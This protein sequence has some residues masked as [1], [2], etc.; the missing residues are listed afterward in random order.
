VR[1]ALAR[2]HIWLAATATTFCTLFAAIPGVAVLVSLYALLVPPAVVHQQLE[3]TGGLLPEQAS[4]FLA[5]Q[6]QAIAS[7]PQLH[8]GA[9]LGGA[10]LVALWSARAGAATLIAACNYAYRERER[11]SFLRYQVVA[12]VVT[13]A[14]CLFGAVVF[15]FVV[16]LPA[17]A[18]MLPLG[19][20]ARTAIA[21]GRWPA[22]GVL[23]VMA[24]AA[25]YRFAPCRRP[26]W[27]WVS[28]GA[29]AATALWLAGS[30]GFSFYVV[31]FSSYNRTLG[32]LGAVLL[33]LSWCYLTAFAVL[34][35]AELNAEM[36]RQT[37]RDT[38]QGPERPAG[39]R[40]ARVADSVGEAADGL[41]K[42][43]VG[44]GVTDSASKWSDWSARF[45]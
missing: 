14:A 24:L 5:D 22:L 16:V 43:P 41:G 4:R 15:V 26:R 9:G 19:A 29:V 39:Q 34:L 8:L 35:G 30:A 42:L 1:H 45:C 12:L 11:R 25:A 6:L 23:M 40:G 44:R 18:G 10:V 38:T 33:L 32:V 37:R 28:T 3:I 2:D 7:A 36:E 31:H 21:L 13:L 17:A 27:R 20:A